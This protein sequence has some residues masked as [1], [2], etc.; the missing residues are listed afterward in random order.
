[1]EGGG[2]EG[3]GGREGG[4]ERGRWGLARCRTCIVPPSTCTCT[5][6]LNSSSNLGNVSCSTLVQMCF[7]WTGALFTQARDVCP[8][9]G[10][11]VT[12]PVCSSVPRSVLS[13]SVGSFVRPFLRPVCLPVRLPC[14]L[15]LS[16]CPARLSCLFVRPS[17][18]LS[19][20]SVRECP[21]TFNE[22]NS[23]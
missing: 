1:M 14:P 8:P 12:P 7:P 20:S 13:I 23:I 11:P 2:G 4:S 3:W 19:C 17:V 18:C 15:V 22:K 5:V 21:A 9:V 6:L 10:N 16:V